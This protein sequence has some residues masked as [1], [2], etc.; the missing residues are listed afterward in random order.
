MSNGS[1]LKIQKIVYR[2]NQELNDEVSKYRKYH[3]YRNI[4]VIKSDDDKRFIEVSIINKKIN[5]VYKNIK[6]NIIKLYDL[7]NTNTDKKKF[8]FN[9]K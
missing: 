9:I 2:K 4:N 3:K 6:Q 1:E 5:E 8:L 7:N